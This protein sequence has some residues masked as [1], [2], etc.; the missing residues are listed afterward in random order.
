MQLDLPLAPEPR[1]E[2]HFPSEAAFVAALAKWQSGVKARAGQLRAARIAT[3]L[4]E[5]VC[6]CDSAQLYL[7]EFANRPELAREVLDLTRAHGKVLPGRTQIAKR[8]EDQMAEY[9]RAER[10]GFDTMALWPSRWASPRPRARSRGPMGPTGLR[11]L[12]RVTV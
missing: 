8:T 9:M 10:T 2:P 5:M 1:P 11:L 6:I 12:C 4:G 7:L 3:P